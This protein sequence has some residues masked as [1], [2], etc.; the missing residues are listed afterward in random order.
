MKFLTALANWCFPHSCILCGKFSNDLC[1]GCLQDLPD[2]PYACPRCARPILD[3][4]QNLECGLCLK[5]PPPFDHTLAAY[6]YRETLIKLIMEL[7]FGHSLT[8]AR[9]LGEQLA[10]KISTDAF[11][12]TLKP[13]VIIPMPLHSSRLQERGFNQ[14]VEI[15]RP[16]GK[17]FSLP[18]DTTSCFRI[19]ETRAQATLNAKERHQNIKGAFK[20]TANFPYESVAILDDVMT[21]GLTL[22]E[23]SRELRQAGVKKITFWC[24]ARSTL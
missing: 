11:Y 3:F 23:L 1:I 19:K 13:E 10:L 4:Q 12:H 6:L 5:D 8:N 17:K 15:A 9:V 2:I 21:T 22:N 18:I 20:V 14:A 24:C 7:K 16:I